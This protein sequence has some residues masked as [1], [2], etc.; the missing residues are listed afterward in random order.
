MA[1]ASGVTQSSQQDT[2]KTKKPKKGTPGLNNSRERRGSQESLL[3]N[4]EKKENPKLSRARERTR[5]RFESL[6][7]AAAQE[8]LTEEAEKAKRKKKRTKTADSLLSELKSGAPYVKERSKSEERLLEGNLYKEDTTP[9]FKKKKAKE[10]LQE[11][12]NKDQLQLP[13]EKEDQQSN[14]KGKRK[15]KKKL[16]KKTLEDDVADNV[17]ED[18]V[19][20]ENVGYDQSPVKDEEPDKVIT[21]TKKKKQKRQNTEPAGEKIERALERKR[22]DD[23]Y[24][25]SIQIHKADRLKPDIDVVHPCIRVHVIDTS[26]GQ[27]V[28]KSDRGRNVASFFEDKND[29]VDYIMPMMTQP[30]D[31]R[32]KKSMLPC[33]EETLIYN[34]IYSYFLQREEGDPEVMIF[35]E[36]VDFLSMSSVVRGNTQGREQ[37][38]YKIAWAFLKVVSTNGSPNTDRKVRL[39]LYHR[40]TRLR[41]RNPIPGA[42][43]IFSWWQ[44]TERVPY[45]STLYVTVKGIR[46]PESIDA[47]AR[48]MFPIQEERGT[49]TYEQLN[50]TLDGINARK[51]E[52][53]STDK[54][55]IW[56]RL[57]GQANRI[58]NK[59]TLILPTGRRGCSVA[60][61]SPD[62]RNLAC[63]CSNAN[64]FP[65]L[66][67]AIPSGS[68]QG[69]LTGHFGIIY[70][71]SWSADG[72]ELLTS[73]SDGTVRSWDV[74][75]FIN[76]A[77]K[78]Y[79]HPSFVYTA[80]HHPTQQSLIVSGGYDKVLRIWTK[81]SDGLHGKLLREMT[82]HSGLVNSII[83]QPSGDHMYSGD[84]IG[85][86]IIW[87][88][89]LPGSSG[90][91]KSRDLAADEDGIKGWRILQTIKL[92]EIKST[93]INSLTLHPNGRKLLVHARD[94]FI[95]MLDLR[96][97]AVM[98]RYLGALNQKEHIRS[99]TSCC[100]TFVIAGSEDGTAHVWNSETADPVFEYTDLG[101]TNAVCDVD[102]HPKENMIVF[103]SFGAGHP[104]LVYIFDLEEQ[105]KSTRV[106]DTM[107][108]ENE[109]QAL[110][111][112]FRSSLQD[113]QRQAGLTADF[114]KDKLRVETLR[115]K[116]DTVLNSS[117]LQSSK[118]Q[119][120]QGPT[121]AGMS[122]TM[123][124]WGSDFSTLLPTSTHMTKTQADRR[125][126][127]SPHAL[128]HF[129]SSQRT[130]M[131]SQSSDLSEM[132]GAYQSTP[133]SPYY[134]GIDRQ[135][136]GLPLTMSQLQDSSRA[137]FNL[138][139]NTFEGK[140]ALQ[141]K[142]VI[143]MYAY[144]PSRSD[145]LQINPSD[146]ITVIYEDNEN[147]WFGELPD[148]RQGYFPANY[149]MVSD[150]NE[151]QEVSGSRDDIRNSHSAVVTKDGDLKIISAPEDSETEPRQTTKRKQRRRKTHRSS[152]DIAK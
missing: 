27:Y 107:R 89:S 40:P 147:W 99:T 98:K 14:V 78:V 32:K 72:K 133:P 145:E 109:K 146:V 110:K 42:L 15:S 137:G 87:K 134:G 51:R 25:L 141:G 11:E 116:M 65:I 73:S 93:P 50:D 1:E 17:T 124:T 88:S 67:Y 105:M 77:I 71:M 140:S 94:A 152:D 49:L 113:S 38:W 117:S 16:N 2:G 139:S 18:D 129:G 44:S 96:S 68:L 53:L 9:K 142:Q 43:E 23:G 108:T 120:N 125:M 61:F 3:H 148:G 31:F 85:V 128:Q 136:K 121:T 19:G 115:Q 84:S 34:E 86:I 114:G 112:T 119:F 54:K 102:F 21:T 69:E 143:A 13:L 10:I 52:S 7:Q 41:A 138:T 48:S 20:K 63:A 60:R 35:F 131:Q 118:M 33:W 79:P 4:E 123:M 26:T 29:A 28:K 55:H 106:T 95:R 127:A 47:A 130:R 150:A 81:A 62:G 66:V 135:H 144:T 74:K 46:P 126:S 45:P 151:L 5:A 39:Q 104:V 83:F 64:G 22:R 91:R 8:G 6:L 24:L 122:E 100:G 56:N 12:T 70:D 36:I 80:K 101:F 58:P 57:P 75:H 59:L 37:G 97:S 149:V 76:N 92:E 111:D 90:K 82:G 103:C 132:K 30:F